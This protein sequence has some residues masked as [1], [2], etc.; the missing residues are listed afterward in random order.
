VTAQ[1]DIQAERRQ[2]KNLRPLV[3]LCC[4]GVLAIGA[5]VAAR[6]WRNDLTVRKVGIEGVRIVPSEDIF[7]LAA[8]PMDKKL[9]D[10]PLADIRERVRKSPFVRDVAVHRD[11]PDRILIQVE[12]RTPIAVIAAG[13]MF[14]VDADGMVLPMI[15]SDSVF[16]LPIITGVEGLQPCES[17]KELSHP[18]IREALLVVRAAQMLDDGMYRRISEIHIE[19]SGGLLMYTA[20]TGVPVILGHGDITAKL[21]KFHEFW[22]AVVT[23]RGPQALASIDLRFSDQVVVRWTTHEEQ[24]AN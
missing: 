9:Y 18:A 17:G 21:E 1:P 8:V 16:D 13:R 14:F 4:I 6:L 11:P 23:P 19:P 22:S 5:L 20:D 2:P 24:M 15:R 12:E 10:V 7:H 3:A